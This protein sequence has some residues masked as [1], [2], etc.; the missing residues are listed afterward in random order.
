MQ[1]L[2]S[3]RCAVRVQPVAPA[4]MSR[5]SMVVVAAVP[6]KKMSKMKT[7]IRKAA[8]K[9]KVLPY[10]E[11]AFYMANLALQQGG[12]NRKS[13]DKDMAIAAPGSETAA[14]VAEA[15]PAEGSQ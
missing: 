14:P 6:K 10:V 9:A 12:G 5:G 4:S 11:K 15:P 2:A 13:S 3:S 8:W 7:D 1:A